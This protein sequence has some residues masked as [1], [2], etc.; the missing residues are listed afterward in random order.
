MLDLLLVPETI[1]KL[2]PELFE[3]ML[4]TKKPNGKIDRM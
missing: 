4:E 3:K 1:G 2:M